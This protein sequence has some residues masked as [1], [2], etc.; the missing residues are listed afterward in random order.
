MKGYK[1]M[2]EQEFKKIKGLGEY[3]LTRKQVQNITGRSHYTVQA[4]MKSKDY[5]DYKELT[6][7]RLKPQA[8][9]EH[10]TAH[11]QPDNS[12]FNAIAEALNSLNSSLVSIDD[13]LCNIENKMQTGKRGLFS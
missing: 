6:T 4:I 10:Q 13:R 2:T 9:A 5:P 11:Q 3:G 7:A 1:Q 12:A 8:R